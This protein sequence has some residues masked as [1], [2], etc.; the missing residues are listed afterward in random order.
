MA[1]DRLFTI[2][3]L[4]SF[5][6]VV[7]GV[8]LMINGT[9]ADDV[10]ALLSPSFNRAGNLPSPNSVRYYVFFFV[11][12][13]FS[14][15]FAA[16]TGRAALMAITAGMLTVLV[17]DTVSIEWLDNLRQ[18]QTS[19]PQIFAGA[20]FGYLGSGLAMIATVMGYV[21]MRP[22][23]EDKKK[24]PERSTFLAV[25]FLLIIAL[26]FITAVLLWNSREL[27]NPEPVRGLVFEVAEATG[28]TWLIFCVGVWFD[29]LPWVLVCGYQSAQNMRYLSVYL[30]FPDTLHNDSK[31]AFALCW[32]V[33]VFI[34]FFSAS[35]L[36]LRDVEPGLA[37]RPI[38][39]TTTSPATTTNSSA[40]FGGSGAAVDDDDDDE[41]LKDGPDDLPL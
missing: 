14:A 31:A 15:F 8:C 4:V 37:K 41:L 17:T 9:Y 35:H 7:I 24:A 27:Q 33:S 30:E 36:F 38:V 28:V 2:L 40:Y 3:L 12:F 23:Q 34:V 32:I 19:I 29:I 5:A 22:A 1:N 18:A 20:L 39:D 25:L 16:F 13:W 6:F 11:F 21:K 26:G 10:D